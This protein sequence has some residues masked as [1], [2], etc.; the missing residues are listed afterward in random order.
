MA[1][2]RPILWKRTLYVTVFAQVMTSL[3]F[4]SFFPF[5]PL[6]VADLGADSRL[7]VEFLSGM[8]G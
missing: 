3:G 2:A 5:L 4:S 6:Y 8:F 7:S 1:P